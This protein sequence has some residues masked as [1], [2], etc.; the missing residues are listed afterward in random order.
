MGLRHTVTSGVFSGYRK[1]KD[2]QIFLQTDAAIN[3]GNSGGP[4]IDENGF[5]YGVNTMILRG[6]EGIGFAIPIEKVYEEFSSSL[7]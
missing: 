3:P 6:T 2:G 1:R 5:V 4:L 7:F